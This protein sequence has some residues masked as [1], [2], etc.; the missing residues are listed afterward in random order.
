MPPQNETDLTLDI[1]NSKTIPEET[2]VIEVHEQTIDE[3]QPESKD[4]IQV[5]IE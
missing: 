2:T 3:E 5:T 1:L 4:S